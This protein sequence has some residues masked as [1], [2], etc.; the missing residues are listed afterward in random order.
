MATLADFNLNPDLQDGVLPISAAASQ[1]ARRL[2]QAQE[3]RRPII[4]TQKGRPTGVIVSVELFELLK[5]LAEV[6]PPDDEPP[7]A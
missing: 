4:V 5:G 7:A 2:K 3:T 1:L 6:L